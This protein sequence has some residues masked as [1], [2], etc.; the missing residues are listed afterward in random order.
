V[1]EMISELAASW[2]N[3]CQLRKTGCRMEIDLMYGS[4]VFALLRYAV[5]GWVEFVR[6]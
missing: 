6:P 1:F 3:E 5:L 2:I 4:S